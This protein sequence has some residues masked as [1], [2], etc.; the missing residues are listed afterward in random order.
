MAEDTKRKSWQ[1]PAWQPR[2]SQDLFTW[3]KQQ[4]DDGTEYLE[5]EPGYAQLEESIRIIAGTPAAP[6]AAKQS[7]GKYSKVQ[8]NR[9]KRNLREMVNA[10]SDIRYTPGYH[11][12]ANETQRQ[13]ELLNR[14]AYSWYVNRFIDRKIH[15]AVQWMSICPRGWLEICYRQIPGERGRR[16]I[17]VIPH[18]GMDVVMTGVPESGDHQEA[19]TVTII[20]DLPVYLAHALWPEHQSKLRPDRETPRGWVEKIKGA[21]K[22]ILSDVFSNE[23][24]AASAK[25]PTV[26]LYYQYVLDLSINTSG[27]TM[28]MGYVSQKQRTQNPSGGAPVETM[29][30]VETPWSYDVPSVGQPIPTGYDTNGQAVYRLANEE[31]ARIFPGRRLIV[32]SESETIYDGP[33][34][35]WHGKVPLVKFSAD[36]WP[37]G[38]FSMVHDVANIHDTINEMERITHQTARNRFDP[39]LLYNMRAFD[40]SK[41]KSLRSDVQ[42]QRVGYN[43]S[44]AQGDNV[45]RPLFPQSFNTI[46]GWFQEFVKY[47]Q[48]AEDYQMGVR[49]VSAMAK[50]RVGASA[51]SLEKLMELAGPIVKG[52]SR[53]MER[54][55]RDLAEM[56][57]Y[58]V[59]QYMTT[60]SI[61]QIVGVDGITPE[62]F[63]YD[64]GNLVPSHLP[65]EDKAKPSV[66]SRQQR[67]KW[68]C[69]HIPFMITPN[70]MHDIV[71]TQMKLVYLQLYRAGFPIDPWTIAEAMRIGGFGKK[72]ENTNSILDRFFAW[73]KMQI[74]AKAE[75]SQE[76][77]ELMGDGGGDTPPNAPGIGPHG[78]HKGTGGRPPSAQSAPRLATKDQGSR[79]TVRE[80][81]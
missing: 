53:D 9:L 78:G 31:D 46:D 13:A 64:P 56:F 62:N 29:V 10:L 14:V 2:P 49:D 47:L 26:R 54:S 72:P 23:P 42:G 27:K 40:R 39:T 59:C 41:A 1:V 21:A 79:V 55:M 7:D 17:D 15:K 76:A 8:T 30:D 52:I 11:S 66:Y 16:V 69:D 19:Y 38:E 6:L 50:M 58:L 48:D 28:K 51:D 63:D 35:D 18:S 80:S 3:A 43:G 4:V 75:L 57:K 60:S 74:E 61:M 22:Q 25:N 65:G 36:A 24:Q 32:F 12:D 5:M 73:Q 71:T 34:F 77:Q 44:E 81:K 20:K 67:A 70:T 37:F 68:L 45:V 33:M